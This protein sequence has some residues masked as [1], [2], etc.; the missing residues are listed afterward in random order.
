[1]IV[2]VDAGVKDGRMPD[3]SIKELRIRYKSRPSG[4]LFM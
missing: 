1:M 3:W 4:L 2:L